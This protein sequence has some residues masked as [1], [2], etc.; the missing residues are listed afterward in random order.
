MGDRDE[1]LAPKHANGSSNSPWDVR[2]L[3]PHYPHGGGAT[4]ES[5]HPYS[6][7]AF[8]KSRVATE[9]ERDAEDDGWD[10]VSQ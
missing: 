4:V 2:T 10:G 9:E 5:R 8:S 6:T 1:H 3:K 7:A